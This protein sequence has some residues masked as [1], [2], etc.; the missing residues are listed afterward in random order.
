M[1][2]PEVCKIVS[3]NTLRCVHP[4]EAEEFEASKDRTNEILKIT[5]WDIVGKITPTFSETRYR[6]IM[7]TQKDK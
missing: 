5:H 2:T 4:V 1:K 7:N 6:S 3:I